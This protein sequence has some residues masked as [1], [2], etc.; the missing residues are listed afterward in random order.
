MTHVA[1]TVLWMVI[2]SVLTSKRIAALLL[3]VCHLMVFTKAILFSLGTNH[4][5]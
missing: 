4:N 3:I 2:N 1:E 5:T